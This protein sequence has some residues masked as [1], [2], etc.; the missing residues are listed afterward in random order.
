M[1]ICQ[2]AE[3]RLKTQVHFGVRQSRELQRVRE[4]A[5]SEIAAALLVEGFVGL[6][7]IESLLSQGFLGVGG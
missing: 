1:A 4:L 7:R 5:H 2:F 3:S 6:G